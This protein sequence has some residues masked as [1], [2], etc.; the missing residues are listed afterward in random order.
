MV[1]AESVVAIVG[2]AL[3][4]VKVMI[5]EWNRNPLVAVTLMR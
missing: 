2:L 1:D 3:V 4:T 5:V